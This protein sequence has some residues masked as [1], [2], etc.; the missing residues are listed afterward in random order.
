MTEARIETGVGGVSSAPTEDH[1]TDR[2]G[3][4]GVGLMG[5]RRQQSLRI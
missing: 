4:Q 1:A 3:T 2:K 5:L